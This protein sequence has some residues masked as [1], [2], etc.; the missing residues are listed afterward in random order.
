MAMP[1]GIKVRMVG[2]KRNPAKSQE[3][4]TVPTSE[5]QAIAQE[6]QLAQTAE[7][8]TSG[9]SVFSGYVRAAYTPQLFWPEAYNVYNDMR[10]RVPALRS[11]TNAI[12]TLAQQSELKFVGETD[13][14]ID[15]EAADFGNEVLQD[16]GY[17]GVRQFIQDA[18]SALAFGWSI[19]EVNYGLR[20]PE[21]Q[22]PDPEDNWRSRFTDGRWGWRS[23][24]FRSQSSWSRWSMTERTGRLLGMIQQDPP[25]PEVF[26]PID[27]LFHF[28]P[29]RDGVN[30]EG[31]SLYESCYESYY[32][33]KSYAV[34]L[35]VGMERSFVGWPVF[36]YE[37]KP[38]ESDKSAVAAAAG[39]L[40]ASVE[41]GYISLP[42]GLKLDFVNNTNSN[43]AVILEIMKYLNVQML[44]TMLAD[45]IWLGSGSTGS[46]SL[47]QDKSELFL[48]A[49]NGI[50]DTLCDSMNAGPV[51]KLFAL[52]AGAFPG[53]EQLPRLTHTGIH[54]RVALDTLGSF[55]SVILDKLEMSDDDQTRIRQ[56]TDGLLSD[57]NTKWKKPEMAMPFGKNPADKNQGTDKPA[58]GTTEDATDTAGETDT[59]ENAE[60]QARLDEWVAK[61]LVNLSEAHP[62][63]YR[64]LRTEYMRTLENAVRD[65]IQRGVDWELALSDFSQGVRDLFKDS[66]LA[67]FVNGGGRQLSDEG[68]VWANAELTQEMAYVRRFWDKL[69]ELE[70]SPDSGYPEINQWLRK[71]DRVYQRGKADAVGTEVMLTLTRTHPTHDSCATCKQWEG[72]R[73][74]A[75]FWAKRNLI[76]GPGS[77]YDCNGFNCGHGLEDDNGNPFLD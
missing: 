24:A 44:Q 30:P 15:Q 10:R 41:K 71:L 14:G 52:N 75:S 31:I 23:L 68:L 67:G 62:K 63:D 53:L 36:S 26:L 46:W 19:H 43:A 18:L 64:A 49:L 13:S 69:L 4:G 1:A 11:M 29:F 8:G 42:P 3:P 56:A 57:V 45:F 21:W 16:L 54:K 40:L 72:K 5:A 28:V 65:Y 66:Y 74:S 39:K 12:I 25:N 20:V 55:L 7:L 33:L 38:G 70:R 61:G 34:I 17:G 6:D 76:P 60:L 32:F 48:M 9:L 22:A 47:G 58:E 73:H 59:E 51:R 50:L 35:G 2:D 77:D 37:N 27:K